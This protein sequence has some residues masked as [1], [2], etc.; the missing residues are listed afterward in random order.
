MKTQINNLEVYFGCSDILGVK[1]WSTNIQYRQYKLRFDFDEHELSNN[2]A[3]EKTIDQ[4]LL[5]HVVEHVLNNID[6]IKLKA[7]MLFT[8]LHDQVYGDQTLSQHQ[9]YFQPE[10]IE[11]KKVL[12]IGSSTADTVPYFEYEVHYSLESEIDSLIDIYYSYHARF[13]NYEGLTLIGAWRTG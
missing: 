4:K 1:H 5:V 7:T 12:N 10:D 2:N 11:L 9:G 13:S 6:A 3:L 8:E